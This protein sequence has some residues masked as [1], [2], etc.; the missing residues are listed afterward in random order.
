MWPFTWPVKQFLRFFDHWVLIDEGFFNYHWAIQHSLSC[1]ADCFIY[2]SH[3]IFTWGFKSTAFDKLAADFSYDP[4][5]FLMGY[6]LGEQS[7]YT[8]VISFGHF[9]SLVPIISNSSK[10]GHLI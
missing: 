5:Y 1:Q 9:I 8:Q 7:K 4:I 3:S 2:L 6:L 10:L